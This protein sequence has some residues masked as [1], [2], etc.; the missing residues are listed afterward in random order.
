M[1]SWLTMGEVQNNAAK[2]F[3]G[4]K[5]ND[6]TLIG[7]AIW[8]LI[9]LDLRPSPSAKDPNPDPLAEAAELLVAITLNSDAK[10]SVAFWNL[11][12]VGF[13]PIEPEPEA[14]PD[15]RVNYDPPSDVVFKGMTLLELCKDAGHGG[16][17]QSPAHKWSDSSLHELF[18]KAAKAL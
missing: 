15:P 9:A 7:S 8:R 12:D 13:R 2:L 16:D 1:L 18:E 11:L 6:K 14:D 5:T 10:A 3:V 4:I 17:I